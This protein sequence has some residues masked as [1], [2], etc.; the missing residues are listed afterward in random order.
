[1][2]QWPYAERLAGLDLL[3]CLA[4][5][6]SA[7]QNV[8][9]DNGSLLDLAVAASLPTDSPPN[10][11][12]V[13]MGL[14]TIAN[15]FNT[16][17]GRNVANSG[18]DKAILFMETVA[19]LRDGAAI[20]MSNRNLLI[21]L[22]TIAVNF[23]VLVSKEKVLHAEQRRRLVAIICSVLRQQMDSEVLYRGLIAVGTF[24]STSRAEL[25]NMG[26]SEIIQ[27]VQAK[28]PEERISAICAECLQTLGR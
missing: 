14:R 27:D 17:N 2:T 20:G 7:A 6:G 19:G 9:S 26:I 1:M 18:A 22:T 21:A 15:L 23:A 25:A 3:R 8:D 16:A 24:L 13:M 12:A 5:Y 28:N 10:V 11:N 4:R